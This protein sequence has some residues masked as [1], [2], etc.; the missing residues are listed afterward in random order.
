M[1]GVCTLATR[2]DIS[3][4]QWITVGL[5]RAVVS[6]V[7]DDAHADGEVVYLDGRNRA[8]YADITWTEQGWKCLKQDGTGGYAEPQARLRHFVHILHDGV[9][10]VSASPRST[11]AA[12]RKAARRPSLQP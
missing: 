10:A 2:P 4:E 1:Q 5:K 9:H 11:N 8:V 6:R 7:Y 12:R 3:P